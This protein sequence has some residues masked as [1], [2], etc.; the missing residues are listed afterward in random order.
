M[1]INGPFNCVRLEGTMNKIH[2]HIYVFFDIHNEVTNQTKCDSHVKNID[3]DKY[4]L[5][6]FNK[7]NKQNKKHKLNKFYDFFF[8]THPTFIYDTNT[9]LRYRDELHKTFQNKITPKRK[10]NINNILRFHCIDIRA[11]FYNSLNKYIISLT[12]NFDDVH[13]KQNMMT[14]YFIKN[15]IQLM[16]NYILFKLKLV[17]SFDVQNYG[18]NFDKD[19]F[20]NFAKFIDIIID[21]YS[22]E[23]IKNIMQN[24][25]I[26]NINKTF[27]KLIKL[28]DTTYQLLNKNIMNEQIILNFNEINSLFIR[29]GS[30]FV[31]VYLM[32]RFL[33][34]N[35]VTNAIA[36]VGAEHSSRYI[37]IL[38]KYFD[39]KITHCS[40]ASINNYPELTKEIHKLNDMY[41]REQFE[42][43]IL[44]K[45]FY[46][47]DFIQCTDMSTFPNNFE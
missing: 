46:T 16:S 4:L 24:I 11:L 13:I 7:L 8:E 36:Y 32:R 5:K 20:A 22:S 27:Q 42:K 37:Y 10:A 31:D 34:K 12:N 47:Q 17:G 45:Y 21:K 38:V 40:Y 43:N 6:Q 39:F 18:I 44:S 35:T 33:D 41:T 19:V 26:I 28:L 30:F 15:V 9:K 23:K 14:I 25:I 1:K 29:I 3:I 2:K